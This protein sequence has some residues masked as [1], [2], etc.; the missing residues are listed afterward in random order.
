MK[1]EIRYYPW[2]E[3]GQPPEYRVVDVAATLAEAYARYPELRPERDP[4]RLDGLRAWRAYTWTTFRRDGTPEGFYA[5]VPPPPDPPI[6]PRRRAVIEWPRTARPGEMRVLA[7]GELV[8]CHVCGQPVVS[9]GHHA[10][11]QHGMSPAAYR[12]RFGL[13]RR[14]PLCAPAYSQKL[15]HRNR[16]LQL[17]RH[18]EPYRFKGRPEQAPWTRRLEARRNISEGRRALTGWSQSLGRRAPQ[19]KIASDPAFD[20]GSVL[21]S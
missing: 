20:W 12:E 6:P 4:D 18:I 19:T 17:G 8:E 5:A 10:R 3:P 14:T 15:W 9:A 2:P 1:L 13:N 16:R 21:R 7:H 11:W